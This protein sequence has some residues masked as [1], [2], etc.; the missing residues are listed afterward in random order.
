MQLVLDRPVGSAQPQ[1]LRGRCLLGGQ[2][3]DPIDVL[4]RRL[5]PDRPLATQMEDLLHTVPIQGAVQ[6][7]RRPDRPPLAPPVALIGVMGRPDAR[8]VEPPLPG[9]KAPRAGRP[10][11]LGCLSAAWADSP[12]PAARKRRRRG[13]PRSRCPDG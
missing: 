1:E 11:R 6:P 4:D 13:R 10:G 8:G 5:P 3:G 12:W 9:G 7:G 2:A